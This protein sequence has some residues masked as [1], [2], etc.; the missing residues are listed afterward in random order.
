MLNGLITVQTFVLM[1]VQQVL[2]LLQIL[3]LDFVF[4]YALIPRTNIFQ[5][6]RQG[7]VFRPVQLEYRPMEHLVTIKQEAVKISVVHIAMEPFSPIL[8]LKLST[9]IVY[10]NV[11]RVQ[12]KHLQILQQ[13]LVSQFAQPLLIYM[14]R[15]QVLPVSVH[16][17]M[18]LMLI[19]I[20]GCAH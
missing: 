10:F 3:R 1:Y 2:V 20:Q 6:T 13:E 14:E 18:V 9:A 7:H 11:L 16:V 17:L 5:T 19:Q 4:L 15:Q 12:I 8:T